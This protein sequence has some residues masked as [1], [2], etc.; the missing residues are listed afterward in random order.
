MIFFIVSS[1]RSGSTAIAN[2]CDAAKNCLCDVEP[3]HKAFLVKLLYDPYYCLDDW[4]DQFKSKIKGFVAA[5]GVEIYGQKDPAYNWIISHLYKTFECKFVYLIRDGREVVRS[6][7]NWNQ[8]TSGIIYNEC[9]EYVKL[10]D[11]AAANKK[12]N[13]GV[14]DQS[15]MLRPRPS[16]QEPLYLKWKN[17]SRAEMYAFY[18][19]RSNQI[20]QNNLSA[21]HPDMQL[22]IDMA[23]V[24]ID[25]LVDFLGLD[26]DTDIANV[27]LNGKINSTEQRGFGSGTYKWEDLG[28]KTKQATER[29]LRQGG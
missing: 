18:W 2:I 28:R 19:V 7:L 23:D 15:D 16:P 27:L 9:T 8:Q 5:N 6:L 11:Q 13:E 12:A 10:S 26:I 25:E 29:I 21:V 22:K 14:Y 1:P 20:I 24:K 17:L 4:M 3:E